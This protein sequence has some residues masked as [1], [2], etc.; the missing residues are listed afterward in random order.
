MARPKVTLQHPDINS[1]AAVDVL[2][3]TVKVSGKAEV[4]A[5]PYVNGGV[6]EVNKQGQE[7]LKYELKGVR[8]RGGTGELSYSY[9]LELY[10]ASFDGSNPAT[11]TVDF[12]NPEI[13][14]GPGS[15]QELPRMD[16]SVGSGIPVVM[17]KFNLPLDT[18][19]SKG[20]YMP[21]LSVELVET[22]TTS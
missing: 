5:D 20:A 14:S 13:A 7:N 18:S 12:G 3:Q 2:C 1:G 11:L 17:R 19:E 8:L 6:A 4:K 22:A 10:L 15:V 9:L 21:A 16:G